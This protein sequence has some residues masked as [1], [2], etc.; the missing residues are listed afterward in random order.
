MPGCVRIGV[1][2]WI[3]LGLL[4]A[5]WTAAGLRGGASE[6]KALRYDEQYPAPV[7]DGDPL[8][9]LKHLPLSDDP[10]LYLSLGG[11]ARVRYER[12]DHSLWGQGPQDGDGYWL[13]RYMLHADAHL[14]S[15]LRVFAQLKSGFEDGR[16]GGPRPPD[17][18]RFDL[19]QL[20]LDLKTSDVAGGAAI[21]RVGRQEMAYGSSRLVSFREGPNVRQSFD[22]IREIWQREKLRV[23]AFLTAPVP[24]KP[25][26]FDDGFDSR[27]RL[28]GVYATGPLPRLPGAN[29]D[30]YYLG[31]LRPEARFDQ[32]TARERRHSFGARWWGKAAAWDYNLEAVFQTGRF[33]SDRIRA[34]TAASDFGYTWRRSPWTPRLGL[35]ADVASGDKDRKDGR[36]G[37]FNPLFP[38]GAYFSES[39]LIGPSNFVDV[40]PSLTFNPR[41]S[42]TLVTDVDVFWRES[43]SDG[44]YG[45]S[46]NVLR[47]GRASA[48]RFVGTQASVLA[49]WRAS[50]RWTVTAGYSRFF[51]GRFLRESGPGKD[52][53]YVTTWVTF[54]F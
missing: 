9:R 50:R 6:F 13:Q 27:Q 7:V 37:S 34:W 26:S 46:V 17:E 31:L 53:N 42:L 4:A 8:D 2:R 24:T 33:G 3:G 28:W 32:G 39:G 44:L 15:G 30:L 35:K 20:F 36:L 52:V 14:G 47:S 10:E 21:L 49:M 5:A 43:L 12:F 29:L 1:R 38:R 19:H 54:L 22:G 45:P 51:A 16:N 48:A 41:R 18:D 40:H 11:E 25:G 23:D